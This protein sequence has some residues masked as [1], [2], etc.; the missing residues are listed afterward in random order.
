MPLAIDKLIVSKH[1]NKP[2]SEILELSPAAIKGVSEGDAIKLK[3]AFGITTI[4]QMGE[5]KFFLA[6]V[7]LSNIG[8]ENEF[9]PGPS[10]F[11]ANKFAQL[12]DDYYINHPSG[13]FR[14]HF[15]GVPYRGRLDDTARVIIVGQDPSTD[16]AIAR[17]AFV[18][19][20]GQRLQK[21]L[22]KLG[23][24]RSYVIINTFAYSINGQANSEMRRIAQEPEIKGFREDLLD[25]FVRRNSIEAVITLGVG[26]REA[27]E[28]WSNP[29]NI[30]IINLFHPSAQSGLTANW[31]SNLAVLLENITPDDA[32]MVDPSPYSGN[33]NDANHR[34]DIPRFDL[35]Y[36]TPHWHGTSGTNSRRGPN[37]MTEITWTSIL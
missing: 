1:R 18:G 17:R 33:W 8:A 12:P 23:I 9:D 29:Q 11:W 3:E 21:L 25:T 7:N 30:S 36:N 31:N 35:P 20:A 34:M 24:I 28:T 4:R 22:H 16:E 15:G 32:S 26:A 2:L 13:R 10:S 37:R 5:N 27:L 14:V 6:A 19:E